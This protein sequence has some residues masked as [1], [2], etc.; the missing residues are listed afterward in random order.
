MRAGEIN[1]FLR[2]VGI[3]RANRSRTA[4]RATSSARC[5]STS[6]GGSSR[7]TR[8]GGAGWQA[9]SEE[10]VWGRFLPAAH[11]EFPGTPYL[12][13]PSR[14]HHRQQNWYVHHADLGI[15]GLLEFLAL[16]A[17]GL[18][19]GRP[20]RL[21]APPAVAVAALVWLVLVVVRHR[22]PSTERARPRR[23]HPLRR[24]ALAVARLL[25]RRRRPRTRRC[26]TSGTRRS[27]SSPANCTG[28]PPKKTSVT[29][30]TPSTSPV[31]F[32]GRGD[33]RAAAD[34][35]RYRVLDIGCG[36]KPYYPYFAESASE[37][38][39]VDINVDEAFAAGPVEDLP[40]Y[41][42]RTPFE[43]VLCTQVLEHAGDPD[44]AIS[45]LHRATA[46]GGRVLAGRRRAGLPSGR[47]TG[48]GR[49]RAWSSSSFETATGPRGR[50]ASG[51]ARAPATCLAAMKL[52]STST[53]SS[54]ARTWRRS[55]RD[56][57]GR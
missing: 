44:Q 38:V 34:F 7:T 19:H 32:P 4:S 9:S 47:I 10:P 11:R 14:Q 57:S 27:T 46:P 36:R 22:G 21:R 30:P 42:A 6:A 20:C 37:Y 48:A 12:A 8:I 26:W 24:A 2:F 40:D 3:E 5:W 31:A 17:S 1:Q 54:A 23:R 49:T 45:E 51:P 35:G 28:T 25:R 18:R 53:W 50:G 56:S 29:Y 15:V 16:L 13:F 52:V 55:R 43:V 33:W 39:G 41:R